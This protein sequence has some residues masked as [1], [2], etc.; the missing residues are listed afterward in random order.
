MNCTIDQTHS[1]SYVD[2]VTNQK[3]KEL[4]L[5]EIQLKKQ[6]SPILTSYFTGQAI[7]SNNKNIRVLPSSALLKKKNIAIKRKR[8]THALR[9]DNILLEMA[10]DLEQ[11]ASGIPSDDD[12]NEDNNINSWRLTQAQRVLEKYQLFNILK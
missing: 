12:I 6:R 9:N 7:N 2:Y 8:T 11:L 5:Q 3:Q 10:H 1:N 4:N